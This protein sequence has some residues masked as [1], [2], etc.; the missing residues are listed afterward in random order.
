VNDDDRGMIVIALGAAVFYGALIG[1][2]VTWLL[3]R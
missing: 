1:A 2:L 3:M